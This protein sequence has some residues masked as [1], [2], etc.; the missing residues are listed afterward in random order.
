MDRH[1][2][3]IALRQAVFVL[4]H[5]PIGEVAMKQRCPFILLSGPPAGSRDTCDDYLEQ[6][7]TADCGGDRQHCVERQQFALLERET[8]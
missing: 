8:G 4:H 1:Q 6:V 7:M 3:P 2:S 5:E